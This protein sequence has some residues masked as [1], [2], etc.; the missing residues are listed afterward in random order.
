MID[1]L[2]VQWQGV[3]WGSEFAD[4]MKA[5]WPT[6]EQH[7]RWYDTDQPWQG[8]TISDD[9]LGT[10][11]VK[12]N[13]RGNF[14]WCERSLPKFM[15]GDNCRV[16]SSEEATEGATALVAA[17]E[18]RFS[19]WWEVP[20]YHDSV[21]VKRLDLC[22]QRQVP[23]SSEV[24]AHIATAL[25]AR[26]VV[27]HQVQLNP[28]DV[29]FLG[30]EFAQSRFERARW[31]DK[32][33]ESGNERYLDVVRH[34]EQIR[35]G[36]AGWLLDVSGPRAD[37]RVE[38]S[39]ERMNERYSGWGVLEG[40]SLDTLLREHGNTGAAAALLVRHPEYEQL[41]KRTLS[42]PSFYRYRKLAMEWRKHQF[43]T[44]LRLPVDAWAEPMVL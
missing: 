28:V 39:R 30:V 10:L 11:G 18:Q 37:L 42:R 34:E 33:M 32:G 2:R 8:M 25:N 22:Y 12:S 43:Q 20:G 31:Y 3:A 23:C 13:K 15:Y 7:S 26:K 27:K 5:E 1:T 44:D 29:H 4:W 36:K 40:Y 14:L 9:S 24:F 17:V 19:D 6:A 35:G 16:L 41:F 21:M 38:E